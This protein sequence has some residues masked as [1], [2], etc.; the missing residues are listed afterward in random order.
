MRD[1]LRRHLERTGNVESFYQDTPTHYSMQ[2]LSSMLDLVEAALR[3][4]L[5]ELR[6]LRHDS[7]VDDTVRRV[8]DKIIYGATP[9]RADV[10]YREQLM[11]EFTKREEDAIR[12]ALV[13]SAPGSSIPPGTRLGQF[14]RYHRRPEATDSH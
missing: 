14:E 5:D 9:M 8:L 10:E 13:M 11:A 2:L 3:D 1:D 6:H 4:E 12:S 7:W